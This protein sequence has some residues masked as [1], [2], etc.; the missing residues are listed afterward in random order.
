MRRNRM[1]SRLVVLLGL[2]CVLLAWVIYEEISGIP[3]IRATEA[4]GVAMPG[5]PAPVPSEATF[6]MPDRQSLAVILERPLFTQT[7]RPSRV[8]SGGALAG[9]AD[10]TLSGVLIS[11]DERSALIRAGSTGTVH[12]LKHGENIAGWTLVEIAA[13]RVIV[14]RD[15][16]ETEI[17]LDYTASAPPGPRTETR[18]QGT[19]TTPTDAKLDEHQINRSSDPEAQSEGAPAN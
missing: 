4:G 1:K 10:F 15:A 7:R 16:I 13:D 2:L 19:S 5:A 17:F 11:G 8:A 18:K 3:A 9:S 14:R 6:A 12:Q